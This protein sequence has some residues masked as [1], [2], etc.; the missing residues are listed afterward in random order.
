[1]NF[2]RSLKIN[3]HQI[4]CRISTNVKN[5]VEPL[6]EFTQNVP[7]P[8]VDQTKVNQTINF[9]ELDMVNT[10]VK[11]VK[12]YV[13]ELESLPKFKPNIIQFEGFNPMEKT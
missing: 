7:K 13:N 4:N 11:S 12:D 3:Y 10:N 2:I 9:V 6:P 1:M 5:D 8:K